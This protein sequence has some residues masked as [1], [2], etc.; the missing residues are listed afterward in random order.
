MAKN[1][2]SKN[3][4]SKNTKIIARVVFGTLALGFAQ[5]CPTSQAWVRLVDTA[6]PPRHAKAGEPG[7]H[8]GAGHRHPDEAPGTRLISTTLTA[9]TSSVGHVSVSAPKHDWMPDAVSAELIHEQVK[10]YHNTY[11]RR[12]V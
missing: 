8:L 6:R 7:D 4:N 3:T 10:L 9:T 11:T 12:S 5:A 2:N 1:E